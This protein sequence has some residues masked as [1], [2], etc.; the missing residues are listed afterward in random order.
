MID[1]VIIGH[2]N[3]ASGLLSAVELILG[4][5]KQIQCIEL[6]ADDTLT[7]FKSKL[8]RC[9]SHADSNHPHLVFCDLLGGSPFQVVAT[10][11]LQ[12]DFIQIVY[13]VNL[14]MLIEMISLRDSEYGIKDMV[15]AAVQTGIN[16]VGYL[17]KK[18]IFSTVSNTTLNEDW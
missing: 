18:E 5:Q 6:L 4:P 16:Q 2:A 13:G 14:G 7:E 1:F 9:L 15:D 11:A 3:I 10:E 12:C 8:K 17:D